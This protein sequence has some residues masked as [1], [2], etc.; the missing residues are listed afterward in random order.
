MRR[1]WAPDAFEGAHRILI[2]L[3]LLSRRRRGEW[4]LARQPLGLI[5]GDRNLWRRSLHLLPAEQGFDLVLRQVFPVRIAK[6]DP[7]LPGEPDAPRR[8]GV[9]RE[10]I[11]GWLATELSRWCALLDV[12]LQEDRRQ[13]FL[14]AL[15]NGGGSARAPSTRPC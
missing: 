14:K 1:C 7:F 11:P 15:E 3:E 12:V 8:P 10:P 6:R 5:A 13:Q 2:P 9:K 4:R